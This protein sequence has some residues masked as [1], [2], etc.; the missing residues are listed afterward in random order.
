MWTTW[1]KPLTCRIRALSNAFSSEQAVPASG[2]LA[3]LALSIENL[4]EGCDLNTL[5]VVI[6][7][8]NG[9]VCY[10]GPR[11][12]NGL[13]QVNVF[14]PPGTR[15]GL[16]RVHVEWHGIRLCEDRFAH[17]MPP[18]PAVPRLTA[19][20]D[21][22]NLMSPQRIESGLIKATIEE[23]DGIETF[24]AT[25]D[26]VA[27]TEVETFRTDPL[28]ERWEVNFRVPEQMQAGGHVLEVR[29]GKRL[30]SRMGIE[31]VK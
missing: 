20:S 5:S 21:A 22:V 28:T 29:L 26:G 18:G 2:R 8:A 3:C 30:L 31:V 9:T 11:A 16:A 15:T 13:S 14:L 19:L 23:V 10:I 25:V 27:A 12:A 17:V 1:Q 6:G 7:G 24:A 4:P